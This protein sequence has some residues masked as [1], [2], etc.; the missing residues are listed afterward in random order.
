[1]P[2]SRKILYFGALGAAAT[3]AYVVSKKESL[4]VVVSFLGEY[5][6]ERPDIESDLA[7]DAFTSNEI[8]PVVL[9]PGHTHASAAG[10]RT[11]ATRFA[12]TMCRHMG[13]EMYV[14]GMSRSDQRRG[15]RGS[16]QWFWAKDVNASNRC[17]APSSDELLYLCD[18]DYYLDM[19]D[20]LTKQAKP[21]LIYTVVP[22]MAT[23]AGQDDTSFYFTDKGTLKTFVAGG[24]SY[25]HH[26]WTYAQDS[27]IA[28]RTMFG[29][30]YRAVAYA[31][32]RK[33][34]GKHR[35]LIL[36]SPMRKWGIFTSWIP[37]LLLDEQSLNRFQP[38]IRAQDGTP[39]V[40]FNVVDKDGTPYT[41][42]ARPDSW[43][44][45]TVQSTVDDCIASAARL[46]TTHLMLPTT[47]SW[48][49]D[50]RSS[51]VVLTEYHRKVSPSVRPTVFPVAQGVRAYQYKPL[52]FD[53][54]ARPKLSAFMSPL[55]HGAFAPVLNK[56]GEEACVEGRIN[57]LKKSEPKP[58]PFRDQC[59][60]EFAEL[61]VQ[62]VHLEPV[63]YESVDSKQTSAA[64]KLSLRKAVLTG[65]YRQM[66]LKCFCKA[67][68]YPD[69]KD[70]RN[71]STYNDADKLDMA[72]FA[73]A[74][75]EH[76]KQFKWYG[77]GKTPLE[78]ANRVAEICSNAQ[79]V[80]ISDYHRMDGTISYVLR[81]VERVICM[82]AFSNHRTVL[83]ELLKT[84][85]DN[86]GYLPYGTTFDQG[87][88]HGSGCSAT[89]LFQTLRAAFT[90]YLAF[91]NVRKENGSEYSPKQ[92]FD[93]LGIHLGDDG[94][95]ADLPSK[96][97]LWAA[98]K[99]GLILEANVLQRGDRGVNF[100]ARYYSPEVWNGLPDSM[101][102]VKRQ[103]SKF[104]VTVRLPQGVTPEQKLV[105]KAMS[106]VATDGNTPVIGEY[107]KRVLLLSPFRPKCL[108]GVGNWWS[109]FDESVQYPNTNVGGW[110]DVE[111]V[112]QFEDFDRKLFQQWMATVKSVEELLSAPL[113][114]TPVAATPSRVDVVVDEDVLSA[115]T[116][117]SD[118]P[119]PVDNTPVAE[120]RKK[121]TRRKRVAKQWK[122]SREGK[123]TIKSEPSKDGTS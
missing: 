81:R 91:R 45:A 80:N 70:P 14:V 78:I 37:K 67:E 121:P 5:V 86:K 119:L 63:C 92:A 9:T 2:P 103:L 38:I 97:H 7:R 117:V 50:D 118:P 90:A 64:Q 42:T 32:E 27:L 12:Q 107:C 11:T 99:V 114:C 57:N 24:G 102:D 10:L 4:R 3:L 47:A 44:S 77:P 87:P 116:G 106:Y 29:V 88:S 28:Y 48:I 73:L 84:N 96:N 13:V 111:F 61:I 58:S 18:L 89:S 104:H 75:S 36:L 51:A 93:A 56:A 71:I 123:S 72:M 20:M 31:V 25:E 22:E 21:I 52:E 53:Q 122:K 19:P 98:S 15:L 74:L 33:Q 26:L 6:S 115:R 105:E 41:T 39:F 100:L 60:D 69:V 85:V 54:E 17:D 109:K 76:C 49:K 65:H 110:M 113:F 95:D 79:T 112:E 101:C 30:P 23:S 120:E 55:V 66:V 1:M 35:Q 34:V 8:D 108:H 82:K 40:R 43:L 59:M 16:R 62:N 46:G 94:L 68:A 83:N